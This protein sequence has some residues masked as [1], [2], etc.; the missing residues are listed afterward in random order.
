VVEAEGA[1]VAAAALPEA[2]EDLTEEADTDMTVA[3]R[4]GTL[5]IL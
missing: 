4:S 5:A 3:L 1:E 2:A